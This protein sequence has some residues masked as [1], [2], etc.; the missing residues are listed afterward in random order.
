VTVEIVANRGLKT[1]VPVEM[2]T[3]WEF[4]N[5]CANWNGCQ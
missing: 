3:D 5:W 2:V 4:K 1:D